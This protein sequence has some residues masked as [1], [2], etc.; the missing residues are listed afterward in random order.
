MKKD[1]LFYKQGDNLI[2]CIND[3]I[4]IGCVVLE[5]L[6]NGRTDFFTIHTLNDIDKKNQKVVIASSI[7]LEGIPP[8]SKADEAEWVKRGCPKSAKCK[9]EK[10]VN[11]QLKNYEELERIGESFL[12]PKLY[13]GCIIIDWGENEKKEKVTIKNN[14]GNLHI[15]QH[16]VS[17]NDIVIKI[18]VWDSITTNRGNGD[19][20]DYEYESASIMLDKKRVI[21]LI[22]NLN[23][24]LQIIH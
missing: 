4:K 5:T 12:E 18:E 10:M 14:H 20:E 8:I 7:K 23:E 9:F 22:A 3:E 15:W 1:I 24:F 6:L 17:K 13:N 16:P 2:A 11:I 21:S 19:E